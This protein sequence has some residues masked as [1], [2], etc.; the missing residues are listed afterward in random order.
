MHPRT[1]HTKI[2]GIPHIYARFSTKV[3]TEATIM[4]HLASC[5]ICRVDENQVRQWPSGR[6]GIVG[7]VRK[8]SESLALTTTT[9]V[10]AMTIIIFV[11]DR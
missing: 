4:V 1:F 9:T 3:T 8:G 10:V 7:V 5:P 2:A 11:N 6:Y